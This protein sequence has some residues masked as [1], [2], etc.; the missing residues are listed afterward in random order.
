ML[1]TFFKQAKAPA[2]L[3]KTIKMILYVVTFA[4]SNKGS[5]LKVNIGLMIVCLV[6]IGSMENGLCKVPT[7][8]G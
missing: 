6:H 8:L 4:S 3:F 2:L 5:N 1:K 7:Y